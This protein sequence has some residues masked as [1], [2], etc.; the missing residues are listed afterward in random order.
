MFT[1]KDYNGPVRELVCCFRTIRTKY[2]AP[3][4]QNP[5]PTISFIEEVMPMFITLKDLAMLSSM[6]ETDEQGL[7]FTERYPEAWLDRMEDAGLIQVWRPVEGFFYAPV[8]EWRL[9]LTSLGRSVF[10]Q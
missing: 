4:R 2:G 1:H 10:I 6:K 5:F 8:S 7:H 9:R 3:G